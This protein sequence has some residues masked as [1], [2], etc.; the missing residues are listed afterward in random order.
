MRLRVVTFTGT[1]LEYLFFTADC[2]YQ[3][4]R[5]TKESSSS[6]NL[7]ICASRL[8]ERCGRESCI[9]SGMVIIWRL[10]CSRRPRGTAPAV[11]SAG[12]LWARKQTRARTGRAVDRK[13]RPTPWRVFLRNVRSAMSN[14]AGQLGPS[15]Q[16]K[17]KEPMVL[18]KMLPA[19]TRAWV[20]ETKQRFKG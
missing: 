12:W 14:I 3:C 8:R 9:V 1:L 18:C 4:S 16:G 7:T 19:G 6:T 20:T 11:R 13:W 5:R 17:I 10:K 2:L 15:R